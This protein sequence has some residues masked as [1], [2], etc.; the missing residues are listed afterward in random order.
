VSFPNQSKI[1]HSIT[2]WEPDITFFPPSFL[3]NFF[4]LKSEPDTDQSHTQRHLYRS[5]LGVDIFFSFVLLSFFRENKNPHSSI[6]LL[7]SFSYRGGSASRSNCLGHLDLRQPFFTSST[8]VRCQKV[9][10]VRSNPVRAQKYSSDF[11]LSP[12]L[13]SNS[14]LS[15]LHYLV[16]FWCPRVVHKPSWGDTIG[17][18][19]QPLAKRISNHINTFRSRS[20]EQHAYSRR[21]NYIWL[22]LLTNP[23][24]RRHTPLPPPERRMLLQQVLQKS[25]LRRR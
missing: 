21:Q 4:T 17:F 16:C 25:P 3:P 22:R 20:P 23:T 2:G 19:I 1:C 13:S 5:S 24:P 7:R 18:D 15:F 12:S 6:S 8:S 11:T 10:E 9:Y 14:N